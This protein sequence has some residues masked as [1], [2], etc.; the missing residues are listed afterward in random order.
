MSDGFFLKDC[1]R[2]IRFTDT[3]IMKENKEE[4]F[5]FIKQIERERK[6]ER[7]RVIQY[8]TEMNYIEMDILYFVEH[9]IPSWI[10]VCS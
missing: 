3:I 8:N 6:E 1:Y 5:L 9:I 10:L 2:Y 7:K 4:G